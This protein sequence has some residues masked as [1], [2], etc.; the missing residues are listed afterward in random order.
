MGEFNE[1]YYI[2]VNESSINL[3]PISFLPKPKLS[4]GPHFSYAIQWII[5]AI[6]LPV[7]WVILYR[8][9]KN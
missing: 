7:G 5:F 3:E 6:L 9:E 1:K 8:S 4:S 2:Q